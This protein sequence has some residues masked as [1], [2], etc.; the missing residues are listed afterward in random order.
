MASKKS[1]AGPFDGVKRMSAD[2]LRNMRM[3]RRFSD[4]VLAGF[5]AL[6]TRRCSERLNSPS[7]FEVRRELKETSQEPLRVVGWVTLSNS[8]SHVGFDVRDIDD[9]IFMLEEQKR[10]LGQELEE[11]GFIAVRD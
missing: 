7:G 9:L 6:A 8:V 11:M 2:E 1:A 5:N 4:G 10:A 3:Q